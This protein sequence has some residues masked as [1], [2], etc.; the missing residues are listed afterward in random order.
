MTF[1]QVLLLAIVCCPLVAWLLI[2]GFDFLVATLV[3]D[4]PDSLEDPSR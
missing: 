2:E 3:L 4:A 1:E